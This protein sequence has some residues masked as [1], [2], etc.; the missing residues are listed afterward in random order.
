MTID[1]VTEIRKMVV[2]DLSA[3]LQDLASDQP[4]TS[5]ASGKAFEHIIL[6]GFELEGA[7][8][9]WPF[10]VQLIGETIEQIDGA[11]YCAGLSCLVESKDYSEPINV[12]PIAKLRNQLMRRPPGTLGIIFAR[13]GFTEPAKIS[14]R[15][16][17]P[18]QILL[19]EYGEL[20]SSLRDG[21]LCRALVRKYRAAV[22]M[23]MPDYD[24]RK[25]L[26]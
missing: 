13:N 12:E 1:Y 18:L 15:M 22:E 19:W 16:M 7:E 3:M 25:V 17:N 5:W 8:V 9:V 20:E 4:S 26:K 23:G 2:A 6:R 24:T 10:S 14:T 21:T 11:I